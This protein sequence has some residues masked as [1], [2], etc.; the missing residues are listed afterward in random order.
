LAYFYYG[1]VFACPSGFN[2]ADNPDI[3]LRQ[4]LIISSPTL[5]SEVNIA[6]QIFLTF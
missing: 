1:F 2:I 6:S 4:I 5:S 3:G